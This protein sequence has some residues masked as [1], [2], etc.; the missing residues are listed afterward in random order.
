M[1]ASVRGLG[2]VGDTP[3]GAEGRLRRFPSRLPHTSFPRFGQMSLTTVW[4]AVA[5]KRR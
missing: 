5:E 2:W 3:V 4:S 1:L